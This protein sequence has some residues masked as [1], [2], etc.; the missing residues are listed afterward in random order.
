MPSDAHYGI[1]HSA[2]PPET[3]YRS[4]ES[5]Y[6]SA[7]RF[8][9]QQPSSRTRSIPSG[10]AFGSDLALNNTFQFPPTFMDIERY[11]RDKEERTEEEERLGYDP[12]SRRWRPTLENDSECPPARV[13]SDLPSAPTPSK[14]DHFPSVDVSAPEHLIL[15]TTDEDGEQLPNEYH[16]S[17]PF[18]NLYAPARTAAPYASQPKLSP[19]LH[20]NMAL[21]NS[22]NA[23][24]A[25]GNKSAAAAAAGPKPAAADATHGGGGALDGLPA[26]ITLRAKTQQIPRVPD[27]PFVKFGP[28]KG[29]HNA[30]LRAQLQHPAPAYREVWADLAFDRLYPQGYHHH[31]SGAAAAAAIHADADADPLREGVGNSA[32]LPTE[33]EKLPPS[34]ATFL[35]TLGPQGEDQFPTGMSGAFAHWMAEAEEQTTHD[36]VQHEDDGDGADEG[37]GAVR[38]AAS[39]EVDAIAEW[40]AA[41]REETTWRPGAPAA[42]RFQWGH[43]WVAE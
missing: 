42:K 13:P 9:S 26:H 19:R 35:H 14:Y 22:A 24:K 36:D 21:A 31:G 2:G 8:G 20:M 5:S 29:G 6:S 23:S 3:L 12:A 33:R 11:N 38:T 18:G 7:A 37:G 28:G 17:Y 16:I 40:L 39:L 41:E 34:F 1:F 30:L 15:P 27:W 4:S 32:G 43:G 25:Q 10:G